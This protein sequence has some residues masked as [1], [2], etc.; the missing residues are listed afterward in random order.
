MLGAIE[1][2]MRHG[3]SSVSIII[4]ERHQQT[5]NLSKEVTE[6][7][8][9]QQ[10]YYVSCKSFSGHSDFLGVFCFSFSCYVST[11]FPSMQIFVSFEACLRA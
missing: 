7:R 11:Y 2:L 4:V 8:V 6:P 9:L 1:I 5:C 10:L 3:H